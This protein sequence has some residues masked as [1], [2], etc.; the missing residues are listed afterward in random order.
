MSV[1]TEQKCFHNHNKP[2]AGEAF[3]VAGHTRRHVI[4]LYIHLEA[5]AKGHR[6]RVDSLASRIIS[7]AK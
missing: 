5:A 7:V 4:D 6:A 1:E 3:Q 2:L